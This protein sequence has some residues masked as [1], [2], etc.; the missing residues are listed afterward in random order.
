MTKYRISLVTS[1]GVLDSEIVEVAD[2]AS[3]AELL[4]VSREARTWVVSEGDSLKIEV[5]A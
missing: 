4:D 1:A 5:E 2:G 3:Y